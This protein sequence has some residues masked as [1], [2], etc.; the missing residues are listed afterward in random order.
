[1]FVQYEKDVYMCYIIVFLLTVMQII[2]NCDDV[3]CSQSL[4]RCSCSASFAS[5]RFCTGSDT[6][7]QADA[8]RGR[9]ARVHVIKPAQQACSA[10]SRTRDMSLSWIRFMFA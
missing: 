8:W 9:R 4:T 6:A 3:C 2:F 7:F 5:R 10:D 1:M